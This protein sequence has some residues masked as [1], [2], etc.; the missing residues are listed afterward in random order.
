M[1]RLLRR[2]MTWLLVFGMTF[3]PVLTNADLMIAN[4]DEGT[5]VIQVSDGKNLTFHDDNLHDDGKAAVDHAAN[6]N[7][8]A[9]NAETA[10]NS[11]V[12][13]AETAVAEMSKAEQAAADALAAATAAATLAAAV[14]GIDQD[15]VTAAINTAESKADDANTAVGTAKTKDG[16]AKV[17]VD[18]ANDAIDAR[19]AQADTANAAIEAANASK[20]SADS[21]IAAADAAQGEV[22][23]KI[24]EAQGATVSD[25]T[26]Q[27][28]KDAVANATQLYEQADT[29]AQAKLDNINVAL[30][31][32]LSGTD[33][34]VDAAELAAKTAADAKDVAAG[35]D[36]DANDSRD[37]TQGCYDRLVQMVKQGSHD[38]TG[39]R[40]LADKATD[41]ANDAVQAAGHAEAAAATAAAAEATAK[42]KYEEALAAVQKAKADLATAKTAYAADRAAA[43][44]AADTADSGVDNVNGAMD[45]ANDKIDAANTAID[46]YNN[47]AKKDARDA[48][49][50]TNGLIDNA[51]AAI[52]QVPALDSAANAAVAAADAAKADALQAVSDMN[53]AIDEADTAKT[54]AQAVLDAALADLNAAKTAYDQAVQNSSDADALAQTAQDAADAA[55]AAA[56]AIDDQVAMTQVQA[57]VTEDELALLVTGKKMDV[58]HQDA[59]DAQAARDGAQSALDEANAER[60]SVVAAQDPIIAAKTEE[61]ASLNQLIGREA[62]F[63][64]S[65]TGLYKQ[66]EDAQ[67]DANNIFLSRERRERARK[68]AAELRA[69]LQTALAD[70]TAAQTA[71]NT[72]NELKQAANNKATAAQTVL[73]EKQTVLDTANAELQKVGDFRFTP[74]N[75][76]TFAADV[77]DEASYQALLAELMGSYAQYADV[78]TDITDYKAINGGWW[79]FNDAGRRESAIEN[80][81][82]DDLKLFSGDPFGYK[83]QIYDARNEGILVAITN[84]RC[85]ITCEDAAQLSVFRASFA[86]AK[87]KD[88][89]NAANEAVN[90]ANAAAASAKAAQTNEAEAL[91][92]YEAA[93]EAL[94]A[95]QTGLNGI[96]VTNDYEKTYDDTYRE[97]KA[98]KE[99]LAVKYDGTEVSDA[100]ESDVPAKYTEDDKLTRTTRKDATDLDA[101]LQEA[102][103]AAEALLAKAKEA[104]DSAIAATEAANTLAEDARAAADEALEIAKKARELAKRILPEEEPTPGPAAPTPAPTVDPTP[105]F[106]LPTGGGASAVLG[107]RTA[108]VA[109]AGGDAAVADTGKGEA[110][111]ENREEEILP[112]TE[113][114]VEDHLEELVDEELPGAKA[115]EKDGFHWWWLLLILAVLAAGYT[116]YRIYAKKKE[117]KETV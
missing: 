99:D 50:T 51:Q 96:T 4:A 116:G 62:G 12:A 26:I 18:A 110:I 84:G 85:V 22:N 35:Y 95:A 78:D 15:G 59:A 74:D 73:N 105:E 63:L 46:A 24:A 34:P 41:A 57:G 48:I 112:Q 79:P 94:A 21:L 66:I 29:D 117:E 3:T 58:L 113:D 14:E 114:P 88:A 25:A 52:D 45:A 23:G 77:T 86:D 60:D 82:Y 69:Q 16:D 1:K 70:R 27:A 39:A 37:E 76:F 102:L 43:G 106:V 9:Q 87:A 28:V 64:T 103:D 7:T 47:G 32:A 92:K 75:S 19:N 93:K 6:A 56:D 8:A 101:K 38:V 17:K 91:A 115:P 36:Q 109:T 53:D 31:D 61:I 68:L 97:K 104:Y 55:K 72:A 20:S 90:R 10:A 33:N 5:T 44:T 71:L 67:S 81:Y 2:T 40:N 30:T 65:A 54:D 100:N 49:D 80:K 107:V 89:Q 111:E 13:S 108:R 42:A 11:A 83:L 98:L